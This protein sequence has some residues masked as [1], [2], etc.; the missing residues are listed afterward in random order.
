MSPFFLEEGDIEVND[1][2]KIQYSKD[3]SSVTDQ[4]FGSAKLGHFVLFKLSEIFSIFDPRKQNDHDCIGSTPIP[5]TQK[6]D[7]WNP[8]FIKF[9][10]NGDTYI[11]AYE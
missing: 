10:R 1:W 11:D 6:G 8:N 4:T 3:A 5:I 2:P 7:D 9:E